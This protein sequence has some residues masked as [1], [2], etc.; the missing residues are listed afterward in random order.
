MQNVQ[1][2]I[3]MKIYRYE[4]GLQGHNIDKLKFYT[5]VYVEIMVL[6]V[7]T[8]YD[9]T[10]YLNFWKVTWCVCLHNIIITCNF[11][12]SPIYALVSH[13]VPSILVHVLNFVCILP[14]PFPYFL[15]VQ[16]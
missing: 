1:N 15:K 2:E 10:D 16:D 14:I 9:V 6:Y 5:Y 8:L 4:K 13:T 11:Y 12:K 3:S 7:V